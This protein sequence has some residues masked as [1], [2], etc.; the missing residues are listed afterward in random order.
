MIDRESPNRIK[1]PAREPLTVD[2]EKVK[3]KTNETIGVFL[4][5]KPS[6]IPIHNFLNKVVNSDSEQSSLFKTI[7][8]KAPEYMGFDIKFSI[9]ADTGFSNPEI[10]ELHQ[11]LIDQFKNIGI[12]FTEKDLTEP[13]I[14][15]QTFEKLRDNNINHKFSLGSL[16]NIISLVQNEYAQISHGTRVFEEAKIILEKYAPELPSIIKNHWC[17]SVVQ[18]NEDNGWHLLSENGDH[19]LNI[20]DW[21]EYDQAEIEAKNE[22][23]FENIDEKNYFLQ[24]S[25]F[26]AFHEIGHAIFDEQFEIPYIFKKNMG[27]DEEFWFMCLTEGYAIMWERMGEEIYDSIENNNL[28]E[29]PS[30]AESN[31]NNRNIYL[32][33][34]KNDEKA[35]FYT[36]GHKMMRHLV[37]KLNLNDQNRIN[38]ILGVTNYLKN[39]DISKLNKMNTMDSIQEKDIPLIWEKIPMKTQSGI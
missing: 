31:Y 37:L 5:E 8:E 21:K 35:K 7:L 38:Q 15:D 1:V 32:N 29:I 25:L 3:T 16:A 28:G 12:N 14:G 34:V 18:H 19:F 36:L 6:A 24:T 4:T 11:K 27:T 30:S 20:D 22:S 39:I 2:L 33:E 23:I 10:Q 26:T 9:T 17:N 13:F